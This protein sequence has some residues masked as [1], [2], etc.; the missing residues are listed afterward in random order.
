M[1]SGKP[2]LPSWKELVPPSISDRI[3]LPSSMKHKLPLSQACPEPYVRARSWEAAVFSLR[4]QPWAWVPTRVS[5]NPLCPLF[6]VGSPNLDLLVV[7]KVQSQCLLL[8]PRYLEPSELASPPL[9]LCMGTVCRKRSAWLQ[10]K[11]TGGTLHPSKCDCLGK[12]SAQEIFLDLLLT[13][14]SDYFHP[15]WMNAWTC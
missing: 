7:T 11:Q 10:A 4:L 15:E 3:V 5:S 13:P 12:F 14:S 8:N 9:V 2:Q 1:V 6:I